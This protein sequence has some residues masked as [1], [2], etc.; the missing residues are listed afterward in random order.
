M[1]HYFKYL[2]YLYVFYGFS[3]AH[4]GAY[5]DFFI[6]I[7]RDDPKTIL[8]LMLRGFDPNTLDPSRQHGLFIAMREPSFKVAKLLIEVPQTNLNMTNDAGE[9]PLMMAALKGHTDLVKAII[10]KE[11]EVNKT[12]WTALH[13]ASTGGHTEIIKLLL[14]KYAYIDAA[15]PNGTTPLMMAAQYGSTEAVKLLL[16]EGADPTI[17]SQLGITAIEFAQMGNHPDSFELITAAV[18][19]KQPKGKW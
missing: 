9:T 5:E 4:A 10:A 17:K 12:G 13:Y 16:D 11:P 19:A 2:I 14:D 15:S 3:F 7:K 18:R 8:T 1:R 6:A